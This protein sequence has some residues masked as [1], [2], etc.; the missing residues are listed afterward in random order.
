MEVKEIAESVRGK[1]I[2]DEDFEIERVDVPEKG[3]ESSLVFVFD[4]KAKGKIK[5]KIGCVVT[6]EELIEGIDYRTAIL[7]DDVKMAFVNILSIFSKRKEIKGTSPF[8]HISQ[9]AEIE[10][11]V[12]VS[13]FCV[14]EDGAIIKKGTYLYPF[15]YIGENSRIGENCLIHPNVYIGYDCEIGNNCQIFAGCVI[16]SDG[17][18]YIDTENGLIK[19]PQTGRVVIEDDCEIGANTTIDRATIGETRI[20][21]G[22]KIDNLVQIAHNCEIGEFTVIAAQT[23]I[24]GSCKTGKKVKMAG[25]V[26][27]ADHLNIG[28]GAILTAKAG[29]AKDVPAGKVY[30]GY[31]AREHKDVL[32]AFMILYSLPKYWDKIKKIL[33]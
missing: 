28:D 6:K 26:G 33:K 22:T 25:Q 20:K 2:G 21:R 23:G 24:A 11:G 31:F 10:E 30:S 27:I 17:F 14:I 4:E 19:I 13:P 3:D 7:V 29:V 5:G 18:G 12:H 1:I 9:K 32:K 8:A 16:G 15:I